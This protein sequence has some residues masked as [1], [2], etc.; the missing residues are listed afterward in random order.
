M[1]KNLDGFFT[2]RYN[3][4]S[5]PKGELPQ[6]NFP[7]LSAWEKPLTKLY[8]YT[9]NSFLIGSVFQLFYCD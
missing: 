5:Y 9:F 3:I 4:H 1:F 2:L 6:A 7:G 8:V